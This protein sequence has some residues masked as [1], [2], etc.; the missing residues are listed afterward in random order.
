MILVAAIRA[1]LWNIVMLAGRRQKDDFGGGAK[2]KMR[3]R[4]GSCDTERYLA[5]DT[6]LET[7]VSKRTLEPRGVGMLNTGTEPTKHPPGMTDTDTGKTPS[8][9]SYRGLLNGP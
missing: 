9:A 6:G 3:R 7:K 2:A 4:R 1:I 5:S 8:L